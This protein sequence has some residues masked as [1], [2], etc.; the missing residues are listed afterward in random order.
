MGIYRTIG[1]RYNL[2]PRFYVLN[3]K[4][5]WDVNL[6]YLEKQIDTDTRALVVNNPHNPLGSVLFRGNMMKLLK[7][8]AKYKVP[9]IADESYGNLNWSEEEEQTTTFRSPNSV[10]TPVP[11]ITVGG[12]LERYLVPGWRIGWIIVSDPGGVMNEFKQGI[13]NM[14]QVTLGPN[15]VCQSALPPLL[16]ETPESF[17]REIKS[18]LKEHA[19]FMFDGLSEISTLKPIQPKGGMYMLVEVELTKL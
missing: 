12:I 5:G 8:C 3:P 6:R 9:L 1:S 7:V 2:N 11:V 19:E 15:S 13:T 18:T 16:D 14:S 17:F 4:S 10:D